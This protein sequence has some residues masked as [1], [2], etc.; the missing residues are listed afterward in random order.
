MFFFLSP[1]NRL[2]YH[3]TDCVFKVKLLIHFKSSCIFCPDLCSL[4]LYRDEI[5]IISLTRPPTGELPEQVPGH[6]Q[7]PAGLPHLLRPLHL[8]CSVHLHHPL[9][10][11]EEHV[12]RGRGHDAGGLHGHR[13]GRGHAPP[14]QRAAGRGPSPP[15]L[16]S[17]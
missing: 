8:R 2:L 16:M 15:T 9:P 3:V 13:G 14:L 12:G 7:H 10:G 17:F 1:N 4:L 5:C 6:L 11:V